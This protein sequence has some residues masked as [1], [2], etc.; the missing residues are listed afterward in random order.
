MNP[1]SSHSSWGYRCSGGRKRYEA[2]QF[3]EASFGPKLHLLGPTDFSHRAL[4]RPNLDIV[5]VNAIGF[6]R[7][8]CCREGPLAAS[9][10][11]AF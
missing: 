11:T 2:G 3:A 8:A 9:P 1:C 5:M 4:A 6:S 10:L 7:I